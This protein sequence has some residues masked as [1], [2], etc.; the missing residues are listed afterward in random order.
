MRSDCQQTPSRR[1]RHYWIR[2]L[3]P[4]KEAATKISVRSVLLSGIGVTLASV[5]V[6]GVQYLNE[7]YKN[8]DQER[9]IKHCKNLS[10]LGVAIEREAD[11]SKLSKPFGPGVQDKLFSEAEVKGIGAAIQKCT[12][13]LGK[14]ADISEHWNGFYLNKKLGTLGDRAA[15]R[16]WFGFYGVPRF[17]QDFNDLPSN[18]VD[19]H[20]DSFIKK[21]LD[22]N[23][24]DHYANK[25]VQIV[26]GALYTVIT[27]CLGVMVLSLIEFVT[28]KPIKELLESLKADEKSSSESKSSPVDSIVKLTPVAAVAAPFVIGITLAVKT[29]PVNL[30]FKSEPVTMQIRAEPVAVSMTAPEGMTVRTSIQSNEVAAS[31]SSVPMKIMASFSESSSAVPVKIEPRFTENPQPLLIKPE[32]V[33][34]VSI[35]EIKV[36]KLT[37]QE[38]SVG[39]PGN[40]LAI[41]PDLQA[42][43][44]A[45]D[46]VT[47]EL[48]KSNWNSSIIIKKMNE[49][50]EYVRGQAAASVHSEG[51]MRDSEVR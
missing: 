26:L 12:E 6:F 20:K 4:V 45:I 9:N 48:S 23:A 34:D 36:N 25:V 14:S 2:E 35:K 29:D 10:L 17:G 37:I 22:A 13:T 40:V 47:G 15:L 42:V 44:Q 32:I 46:G 28:N 43:V 24:P 49:N 51:L 50:I 7:E 18:T 27:L 39:A 11:W 16:E 21:L 38:G 8:S 3:P 30:Q 19:K 1:E 5:L 41:K 31:S 33:G